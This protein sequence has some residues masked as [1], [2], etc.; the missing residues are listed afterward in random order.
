M[1]IIIENNEDYDKGFN[2]AQLELAAEI[3]HIIM[4]GRSLG[5]DDKEIIKTILRIAAKKQY[6]SEKYMEKYQFDFDSEEKEQKNESN[7]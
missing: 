4:G 7:N 3:H 1:R 6:E 5:V 2:R